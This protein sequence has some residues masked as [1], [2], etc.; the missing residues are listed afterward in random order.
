[1]T[2]INRKQGR[3][4]F[5][6][7]LGATAVAATSSPL[8]KTGR[9]HAKTDGKLKVALVGTGIRGSTMWGK[10]VKDNYGDVVEFDGLCDIN[11]KRMAFSKFIVCFVDYNPI[12]ITKNRQNCQYFI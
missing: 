11:T 6:G 3:R 4:N 9:A 7:A 10:T 12:I 1:M 8:L 5:L 2:D